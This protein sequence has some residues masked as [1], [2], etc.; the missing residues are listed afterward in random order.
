MQS[1]ADVSGTTSTGI[2][3]RCISSY[4]IEPKQS[5]RPWLADDTLI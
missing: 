1:S 3:E 5:M 2:G 4:V